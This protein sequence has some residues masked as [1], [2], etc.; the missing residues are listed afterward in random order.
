MVLFGWNSTA[1]LAQYS[2]MVEIETVSRIPI[3]YYGGRLFLQTGN[4]YISAVNWV[5]T[6]K[7]GLLVEMKLTF[8]KRA[9]SPDLK[10][11]IKFRRSGRHLENRYNII[12]FFLFHLLSTTSKPFSSLSTRLAYAARFGFFSKKTRYINS[13]LLLSPLRMDRFGRNSAA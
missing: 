4:S 6:T 5:I 1:P 10:P 11:G 3:G 9:T 12:S 7:F 2:D 13:L 8:Q